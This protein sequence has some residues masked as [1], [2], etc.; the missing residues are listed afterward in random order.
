M[1]IEWMIEK[2]P[3]WVTTIGNIKELLLIINNNSQLIQQINMQLDDHKDS[4]SF[5]FNSSTGLLKS[6][7]RLDYEQKPFYAFSIF[8]EPN[9][10][11][12]SLSI[13]IKLINI[14]DN[15]ISFDRQS[16]MYT[17]NENN[18]IP[19]YIG[20]IQLIDP[21]R[22]FAFEYKYYLKNSSSQISIDTTTGSIILLTRLDREN[23]RRET[24]I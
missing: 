24:S 9:D 10:L 4:Q 13:L 3:Q 18:L 5:L 14:N 8:L 11:N 1:P 16:L 23:S 21:D 2:N 12:C 19:F 7:S 6:H 20:R 15:P 17:I 22:L